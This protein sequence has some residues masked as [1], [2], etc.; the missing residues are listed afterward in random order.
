VARAELAI[1]RQERFEAIRAALA[2]FLRTCG[3]RD[4]QARSMAAARGGM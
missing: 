4:S 3:F 1:A 2:P